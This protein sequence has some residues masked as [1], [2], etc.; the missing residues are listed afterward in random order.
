MI[1]L[2]KFKTHIDN[3]FP[4]L[5]NYRDIIEALNNQLSDRENLLQNK[6]AFAEFVIVMFIILGFWLRIYTFCI[7]N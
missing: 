2:N 5:M 6:S 4:K 7:I 1:V 3:F